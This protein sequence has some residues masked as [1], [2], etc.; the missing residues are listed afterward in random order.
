MY[1]LYDEVKPFWWLSWNLL[2]E[3]KTLNLDVYLCGDYCFMFDNCWN[4]LLFLLY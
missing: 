1:I 4:K 3:N 2:S